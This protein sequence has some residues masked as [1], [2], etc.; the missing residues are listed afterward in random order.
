MLYCVEVRYT[1][2]R[3]SGDSLPRRKWRFMKNTL[4]FAILLCVNGG[5]F[6][7]EIGCVYQAV[8]AEIMKSGT[9]QSWQPV[10]KAMPF[11]EGDRIR[12]GRKGYCEILIKDGTFIKVDE[13]S[14]LSAAELKLEAAAAPERE[15]GSGQKP[16]EAQSPAGRN[17]VF[18]FL[19]GKAMWL[20]AKFKSAV[21]SKFEVRTPSAVCAVRG[22]AFSVAV[23]SQDTAVGLFEGN[24]AVASGEETRELAQGTEAAVSSGTVTVQPRLSRLME[25]ENKRYLKLK[26]RVEELRKK[27]AKRDDFI[28]SFLAAQDRKIS[29]YEKRRAEKLGKLS[30]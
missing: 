19:S 28:D 3:G 26:N 2:V 11:S 9:A 27:L 29:D 13:R 8:N 20:A 1:E 18:S 10:K 24:L 16:Q 6:A 15:A 17:Y 7:G 21:S 5:L 4:I 30:K 23:S 22:T 14:E 25:V 12:T